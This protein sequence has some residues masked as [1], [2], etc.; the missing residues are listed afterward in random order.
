MLDCFIGATEWRNHFKNLLYD[1]NVGSTTNGSLVSDET[2]TDNTLDAPIQ[3]EEVIFSIEKQNSGKSPGPDGI[4]AEFYKSIKHEI[5]PTLTHFHT[6]T[7]F[8]TPGK[9][10]F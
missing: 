5:L 2:T 8:D 3:E 9:Q 4:G 10:A 7:P 1:E 6:I